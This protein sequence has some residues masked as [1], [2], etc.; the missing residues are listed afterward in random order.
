MYVGRDTTSTS[1][2]TRT[3][4]ACWSSSG[5]APTGKEL[6]A[7]AD[8]YRE[9]AG[10]WGDRCATARAACAPRSSPSA[11]GRWGSGSRYARCSP[12]HEQR[13]W[14]HKTA[15]VLAALPK[16]AHRARKPRWPRFGAPGQAARVR[17]GG[18]SPTCTGPS[19]AS[20]R[21]DHR[22]SRRAPGLRPAE[23]CAPAHLEPHRVDVRYRAASNPRDQRPRQPRRRPRDGLQ[24]HRS[25]QDRWRAVNALPRRSRPRR[26]QLHQR[27]T[28]RTTRHRV[29]VAATSSRGLDDSSVRQDTN[30]LAQIVDY[31]GAVLASSDYF[32]SDPQT[33][34]EYVPTRGV[35]A[36][37]A[38]VGDVFACCAWRR[39]SP[40]DVAAAANPTDLLRA[41]P[42]PKIREAE[43]QWARLAGRP[44]AANRL[45]VSNESIAARP[46]C[47]RST[48]SAEGAERG[49]V[50]AAD[51]GGRAGGSRPWAA[52]A[53]GRGVHV[54]ARC[55][56]DCGLAGP[57]AD[58]GSM[59][60]RMSSRSRSTR[61]CGSA[62]SWA[63][64]CRCAARAALVWFAGRRPLQATARPPL[65][66]SPGPAAALWTAGTVVSSRAAA[67]ARRPG[68]H[69]AQDEHGPLAGGSSWI[70][71]RNARDGSRGR[72]PRVGAGAL[73]EQ[74]VRWLQRRVRRR[75]VSR[76]A[77]VA[78]V[79]GP[80]AGT[81]LERVPGPPRPQEHLLHVV[82]GRVERPG[83]SGSN[84]P[85]ARGG[86]GGSGPRTS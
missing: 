17:G 39:C 34:V 62:R 66:Q 35:R 18:G 84:R 58:A 43:T 27:L 22:R 73:V 9:A 33:I 74:L 51:V 7:L 3:S 16:S 67:L 40:V 28:R 32:S 29:R 71:A 15:N 13:D 5:S 56:G 44:N 14:V 11:T 26:R 57:F 25:R 85:A 30:G 4:C 6:V 69:V 41:V 63:A 49:V 75:R 78:M 86:A 76:Q 47:G 81:L 68:Q 38:T 77:F 82:L 45:G 83:A 1:A 50:G 8:G 53:T 60:S 37:Y 80:G 23:H 36:I 59:V 55:P 42:T 65:A 46:A 21:E 31:Y 10:S 2:S 12:R 52:S 20:L 24:T 72:R 48:I 70:A 64:M 54:A 61:A 79:P 19:F